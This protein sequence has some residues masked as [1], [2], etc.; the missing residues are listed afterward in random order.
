MIELI[1]SSK[2]CSTMGFEGWMRSS[3]SQYYIL[4]YFLKLLYWHLSFH[5]TQLAMKILQ[6]WNFFKIWLSDY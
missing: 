5:F 2:H 3:R 4:K 6:S 1:K